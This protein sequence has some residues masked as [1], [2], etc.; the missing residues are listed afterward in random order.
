MARPKKKD[1]TIPFSGLGLKP[2]EDDK[3]IKLLEQEGYHARQLLRGL[4]R[5]WMEHVENGGTG[6]P[7]FRTK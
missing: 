7:K 3:F 1:S 2:E 5:H 4:V 6:L